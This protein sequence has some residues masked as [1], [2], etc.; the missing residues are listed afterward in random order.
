MPAGA[1]DDLLRD[2]RRMC[3]CLDSER[4]RDMRDASRAEDRPY[5]GRSDTRQRFDKLG[6]LVRAQYRPLEKSL[7]IG[8][9]VGCLGSGALV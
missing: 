8:I 2:E 3:R 5:R 9:S 1:S 6:S 7:Q 4:G